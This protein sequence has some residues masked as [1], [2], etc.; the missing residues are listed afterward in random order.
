MAAD[1]FAG[2]LRELKE[3]SGLS[4]GALGKR[5]HMSASTLHRYVKGEVVPT[6][7]AS[8]ERMARL[9][10]ATPEELLELHRRWIRADALRG[11]KA[12]GAADQGDAAAKSG[13]A[14]AGSGSGAVEGAGA[15][16]GAGAAVGD[17]ESGEGDV[18]AV[19]GGAHGPGSEPDG[20]MPVGAVSD[21]A[22]PDGDPAEV[23]VVGEVAGDGVRGGRSRKRVMYAAGTGVG[24]AAAV[25]LVVG[26]LPEGGDGQDSA[27][28][29]GATVSARHSTRSSDPSP[30]AD[31]S[32]SPSASASASAGATA[33]AGAG[34]RAAASK[35]ENA[36]ASAGAPKADGPVPVSVQTTPH[37][38]GGP[39]DQNFL[40]DRSP[41]NV[42]EPPPQQDSAGWIASYGA[43]AAGRQQVSFTVQG[44]GEETVVLNALHVRVLSSDAPLTW[45]EYAMG[46]G[47]GGG[48]GTKAFDVSLD[49]GNP[50]ATPVNGQRDFPYKVTE[51]DPEAFYVNAHTSGHDVRWQLELDWSS[52]SRRGT[53]KIDDN[54]KP[55]R[56]SA[57]D[58]DSYYGYPLGGDKW[59]Q[60]AKE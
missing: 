51:S 2:L 27:G 55:F 15:G 59:E 30:S 23:T 13:G 14:G 37:Y 22:V 8:V 56:T 36:T 7:F 38:W 34:P 31:R 17:G 58:T 46:V 9:C 41:E 44:T 21:G 35:G 60:Y 19:P 39:C 26:L 25:A 11:V 42:L 49:L 33:S 47:C 43:V 57:S 3:R 10:R 12:D 32:A 45:N 24:L 53:L 20:A 48:V 28:A 40:V 54:G 50:L 4:Y 5:L 52:G 1:D 6:E 29:V 18:P 16:A